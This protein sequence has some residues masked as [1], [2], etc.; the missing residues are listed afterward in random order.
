MS[1]DQIE[2]DKGTRF[3][4]LRIPGDGDC[5]FGSVV[6][7][8]YGV[9]PTHHLFRHYKRQLREAAVNEIMENFELY[10]DQLVIFAEESIQENSSM[11]V[12]VRKYLENMW[13]DGVW[14]G[15]DTIAAL[16]NCLQIAITVYQDNGKIEFTPTRSENEEWP[17]YKIFFRDVINGIRTHYDSVLCF[18]PQ[19]LPSF[20]LDNLET[21]NVMLYNSTTNVTAVQVGN[22]DQSIFTAIHHQLTRKIPTE[23]E[24]NIYRGLVASELENQSDTFLR[25]FGIPP[26]CESD[27]DTYLFRLRIGRHDGGFVSLSLM[28]SLFKVKVYIHSTSKITNRL[29]PIACGGRVVLHILDQELDTHSIYSSVVSLEHLHSTVPSRPCRRFMPDAMAIAAK[30]ARKEESSSQDTVHSDVPAITAHGI[31]LASLNVNGCRAKA[32]RD[33][34][35]A[36]LLSKS[37]HIAA[38]QEANLDCV[39]CLT[40]NYKWYMGATSGN[41]KRGLAILIRIG[42]DV[43]QPT[44]KNFGFGIQYLKLTY[45]V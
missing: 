32:K 8:V 31:R 37:V 39:Y 12:K 25:S 44:T 20:E 11:E 34:I 38:L 40:A 13:S 7:Q 16:C 2:D 23:D 24:L 43:Q 10:A 28:S 26:R 1:V 14:V 27:F 42:L 5:L 29:E 22:V 3:W 33:A 17:S 6:H 4:V 45:K 15:A 36:Y 35:D 41:R 21:Y 30:I 18:R 19:E 9:T